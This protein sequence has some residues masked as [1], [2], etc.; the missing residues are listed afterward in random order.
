[1]TKDEFTSSDKYLGKII[2]IDS[3][4]NQMWT[5]ELLSISSKKGKALIKAFPKGGTF[6]KTFLVKFV[7]KGESSDFNL[8][9][10]E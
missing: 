1:M 4:N 6:R 3:S 10:E 7:L 9:L 5:E 8:N 2:F